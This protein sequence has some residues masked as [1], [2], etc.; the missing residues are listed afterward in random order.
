MID[1]VADELD[2]LE[3]RDTTIDLTAED[4][5]SAEV[6]SL[7]Q[8]L[9]GLSDEDKTVVLNA[10]VAD[11]ERNID[12]ILRSLRDVDK[13]D[14]KEIDVRVEMLG[15]ARAELDRVQDELRQLDGTS[16]DCHRR[17]RSQRPGRHAC[18]WV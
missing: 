13:M 18:C 6:K 10:K 4:H 2:T 17:G 7:S 5:A 15:D 16:G 8:L 3:K 9:A 11:A 14:Q 1:K 12:R